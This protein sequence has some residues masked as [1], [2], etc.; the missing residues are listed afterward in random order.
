MHQPL[1]RVMLITNNREVKD[2][3]AVAHWSYQRECEI[4]VF[5]N[6]ETAV[7]LIGI[8]KPDA[9]VVAPPL[10]GS[11]EGPA[12]ATAVLLERGVARPTMYGLIAEKTP[13]ASAWM[14]AFNNRVSVYAAVPHVSEELHRIFRTTLR[15]VPVSA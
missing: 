6:G 1:K 13:R 7:S 4:T 8:V 11:L 14:E 2:E 15:P 10:Q 9:V 3:F 12:L 5:S